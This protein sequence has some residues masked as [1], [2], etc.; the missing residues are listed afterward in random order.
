MEG[1][2]IMLGERQVYKKIAEIVEEHG[3]PD[4]CTECWK[5]VKDEDGNVFKISYLDFWQGVTS[6]EDWLKIKEGATLVL[7]VRERLI[8][9]GL[10]SE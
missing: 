5:Q 7:R 2:K 1:V 9:F 6:K 10:S 3:N 8:G 4:D